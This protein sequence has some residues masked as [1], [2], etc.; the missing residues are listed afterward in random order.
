[1]QL[2]F[3]LHIILSLESIVLFP[4]FANRNIKGIITLPWCVPLGT[5]LATPL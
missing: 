5:F 1:M 3:N 2:C 4:D